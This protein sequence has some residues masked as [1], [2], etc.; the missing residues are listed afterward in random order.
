MYESDLRL[1]YIFFIQY[2]LISL[3][4]PATPFNSDKKLC[5]T[6]IRKLLFFLI[7]LSLIFFF[8]YGRL[9]SMRKVLH[10][11]KILWCHD[12]ILFL[13]LRKQLGIVFLCVTIIQN[14]K[15][16]I[17]LGLYLNKKKMWILDSLT[18]KSCLKI[19]SYEI[20]NIY[21]RLIHLINEV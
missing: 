10:F 17:A 1:I 6:L 13:L 4:R 7:L 21:V 5:Q 15:L 19:G 20:K 18:N 16:S 8:K 11:G 3:P 2:K 14:E 12:L 9:C